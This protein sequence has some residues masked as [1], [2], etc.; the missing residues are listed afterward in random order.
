LFSFVFVHKFS[1]EYTQYRHSLHDK[2]NPQFKK[3]VDIIDTIYGL[4]TA[5][6]LGARA[7]LA[8]QSI[9]AGFVV[10]CDQFRAFETLQALRVETQLGA[11]RVLGDADGPH[12]QVRTG[13]TLRQRALET[14]W[15]GGSRLSLFPKSPVASS[16]D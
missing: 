11:R 8:Q 6:T 1:H 13:V 12:N 9:R 2:F 14:D 5:P 4:L 3:S 16:F 7:L 15:A 10:A